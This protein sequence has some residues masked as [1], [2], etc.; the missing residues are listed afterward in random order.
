MIS[1][2]KVHAI[3]WGRPTPAI[4]VPTPI[5]AS[6]PKCRTC[7]PCRC[8]DRLWTQPPEIPDRLPPGAVEYAR[9]DAVRGVCPN[10][11]KVKKSRF[12]CDPP[13]LRGTGRQTHRRRGLKKD[14][15]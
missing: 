11:L 10:I 5:M 4:L 7:I 14:G 2:I 1:A 13:R 9:D 12:S 8:V 3:A 15:A 6:G